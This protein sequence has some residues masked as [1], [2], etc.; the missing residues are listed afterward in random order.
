MSQS[1]YSHIPA[2]TLIPNMII[3]GIFAI[4]FSFVVLIWSAL[5]ISRKYGGVILI[6]LSFLQPLFDS[7]SL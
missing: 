3:T 1:I 4:I 5:F 7:N 6:G 2:M